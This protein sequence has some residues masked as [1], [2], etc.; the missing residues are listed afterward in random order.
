MAW[1]EKQWG[2]P[3][4]VQGGDEQYGFDVVVDAKL[5]MKPATL[6][7]QAAAALRMRVE[8]QT[9]QA[10]HRAATGGGKLA[11]S[12]SGEVENDIGPAKHFKTF[13]KKTKWVCHVKPIGRMKLIDDWKICLY[14]AA[15]TLLQ[16]AKIPALATQNAVWTSKT[17]PTTWCSS[18]SLSRL[19][20]VQTLRNLTSRSAPNPQ[21]KF[22]RHLW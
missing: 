22:C 20:V 4:A 1:N 11:A 19:S 18:K 12:D 14:S 21:C 13:T 9:D 3:C 5:A 2:Y 15:F 17:L 6:N 8:A 16:R 10:L 7:C